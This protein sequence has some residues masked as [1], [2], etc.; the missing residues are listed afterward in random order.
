[1]PEIVKELKKETVVA[2][3]KFNWTEKQARVVYNR[4]VSIKDLY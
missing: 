3:K 2:I 4:S 1:M